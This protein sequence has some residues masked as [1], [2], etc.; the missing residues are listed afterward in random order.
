[1]ASVAIAMIGRRSTSHQPTVQRMAP[2]THPLAV[3]IRGVSR[4][5]LLHVPSASD[6]GKKWPVVVMFHGGGGT[7]RAALRETGWA[8]KADK[9][10]FLVAFPEGT[11]PDLSRTARF[12]DNPQT[13]NDGSK[14]AGIGAARTDVPDVEFVSTMLADFKVRVS[15]DDRRVYATGFSNGASMTFRVARELSRVLAAVAPVAVVKNRACFTARTGQRESPT[16]V[17]EIRRASCCTPS[18]GTGITGRVGSRLFRGVSV[19]RTPPSSRQAT[20]SGSSS[21]PTPS[22][23]QVFDSWSNHEVSRCSLIQP[24]RLLRLRSGNGARGNPAQGA[25]AL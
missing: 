5:Y 3:T 12:R 18:M 19:A 7:A 9:E 6:Q 10:G 4:R 15:V 11:P 17:R 25:R 23:E 8:E 13:W 2:G 20:S 1:M 21:R 24:I 14:R 16:V 22:V